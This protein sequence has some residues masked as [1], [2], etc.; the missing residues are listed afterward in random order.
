M[1]RPRVV[2]TPEEWERVGPRCPLD[3]TPRTL[4]KSRVYTVCCDSG[5][6]QLVVHFGMSQDSS[7]DW[8]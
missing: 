4:T 3:S 5:F 6:T 2:M 7:K 1:S 8:V